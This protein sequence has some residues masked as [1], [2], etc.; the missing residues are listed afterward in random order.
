M[1][2]RPL[3]P[4]AASS[5]GFTLVEMIVVVFLLALAMIGILSVFD[6][7]ARIN[8]AESDVADAQGAVRYGIYSMTKAIRMAGAGGLY[9]TQAVLNHR[10]KQMPGISVEN[11]VD[12][13]SYDNVEEGTT[14]TPLTGAAIQV[15]PGTD[16]IEIR[17][18]INSPLVGFDLSTGCAPCNPV[19]DPSGGCSPCTGSSEVHAA[20]VT[21]SSH[22]ND[23]ASN[24]PQFSQIDDYTAGAATNP[25]YVLVAFN[26]DLHSA[27]STGGTPSYS[28]YP[29]PPYNVGMI[30]AATRLLSTPPTFGTVDFTDPIAMEFNSAPGGSEDPV[31]VGANAQSLKNVRHAGILDDLIFFIDNGTDPLHAHPSLAQGTRRG[32]KFDVVTLADDVEDMQIAYGVDIDNN[33]EINRL[34][35]Q[36]PPTD[37][38]ANVS[39]AAEGDEWVPNVPGADNPITHTARPFATTNFY[40]ANFCPRLHAVMLALVAKSHNPDL[41]YKFAAGLGVRTMN[42]PVTIA[43]PHPDTAQYPGVPNA[44]Y[45]R[46]VQTLK[47]NLRNYSFQGLA[48]AGP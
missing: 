42:S 8:K 38:E 10:D 32:N 1:K 20:P 35:A 7:S 44:Q 22:Y 13:N 11:S 39:Y 25:M 5:R 28:L 4:P 31:E 29:Q 9:V 45:R 24:R 41:S 40:D 3:S 2:R 27:C 30:T 43:A 48:P 18:V 14:V 16:M 37:P 36:N 19:S 47:I 6:A 34:I 26:D 17:G 15:R 21:L 33:S 12:E 46:R 23:D